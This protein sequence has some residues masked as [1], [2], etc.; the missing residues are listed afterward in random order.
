MS[1]LD[2]SDEV[3]LLKL[4]KTEKARTSKVFLLALLLLI[5]SQ[6][7]VLP[8]PAC[9]GLCDEGIYKACDG[10]K[11][12]R[13]EAATAVIKIV[14]VYYNFAKQRAMNRAGK[15]AIDNTTSIYTW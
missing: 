10:L 13:D 4:N 15:G 2:T 8:V 14:R 1:L 12:T 7:D 11:G 9:M 6:I 5:I 3:P